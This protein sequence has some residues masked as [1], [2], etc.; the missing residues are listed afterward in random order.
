MA[1]LLPISYEG[2]DLLWRN[3][4][5]I[6]YFDVVLDGIDH[7]KVDAT[8]NGRPSLIRGICLGR[9]DRKRGLGDVCLVV[10]KVRL[11][12]FSVYDRMIFRAHTRFC[13]RL[14]GVSGDRDRLKIL[15]LLSNDYEAANLSKC[16]AAE[17]NQA[18]GAVVRCV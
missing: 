13:S 6:L 11:H 2:G 9:H 8:G 3:Y 17:M 18:C 12:T 5:H 14:S 16:L 10:E 4:A 7:S 15:P 1:C